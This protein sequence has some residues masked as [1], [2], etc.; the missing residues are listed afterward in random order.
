VLEHIGVVA[1]MEGVAVTEH[2][3]MVTS[4][5]QGAGCGAGL[6]CQRPALR[7]SIQAGMGAG[8]VES[9]RFPFAEN[10]GPAPNSSGVVAGV[11]RTPG[12]NRGLAHPP[13]VMFLADRK[14]FVCVEGP[15]MLHDCDPSGLGSR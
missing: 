10:Q 8:R 1:C 12:H 11:R 15:G 9:F 7:C 14:S 2:G 13:G 5:L 4:A 6:R 3:A